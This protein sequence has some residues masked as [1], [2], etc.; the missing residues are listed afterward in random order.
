M[1]EKRAFD[2]GEQDRVAQREKRLSLLLPEE[3][4]ASRNAMNLSDSKQEIEESP[5]PQ[6]IGSPAPHIVLSVTQAIPSPILEELSWHAE[7][8]EE[9]SQVGSFCGIPIMEVDALDAKETAQSL[10]D[11]DILQI[12]DRSEEHTSELQ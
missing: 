5:L 7:T 3:R 9:A 6:S 4:E 11:E 12:Y 2:V 8:M 10:L 1:I